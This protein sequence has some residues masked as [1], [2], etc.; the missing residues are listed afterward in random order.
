[1]SLGFTFGISSTLWSQKSRLRRRTAD[2]Y[3]LI[4]RGLRGP[5]TLLSPRP[6]ARPR[7]GFAPASDQLLALGLGH[8]GLIRGRLSP[9]LADLIRRPLT[10]RD[11]GQV[12]GAERGRLG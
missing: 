6:G 1:M 11:P 8:E 7:D 9:H 5:I 12:G 10:R 3:P 2:S 4:T